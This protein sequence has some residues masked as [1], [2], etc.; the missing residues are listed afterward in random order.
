MTQKKKILVVEGDVDGFSLCSGGEGPSMREGMHRFP[1]PPM[2]RRLLVLAVL[3]TGAVA[4]A[5]VG[6]AAAAS[7]AFAGPGVAPLSLSAAALFSPPLERGPESMYAEFNEGDLKTA[8]ALL[9]NVW[10]ARGYAPPT[11]RA[12]C[13]SPPMSC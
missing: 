7:P 1:F 10:P 3:V 2:R 13:R 4:S 11:G 12:S 5:G 9:V 6:D 8:D